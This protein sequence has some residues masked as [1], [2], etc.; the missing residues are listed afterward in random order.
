MKS[1][2]KVK[3][4]AKEKNELLTALASMKPDIVGQ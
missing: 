4:P 1:L 3:V 2:D